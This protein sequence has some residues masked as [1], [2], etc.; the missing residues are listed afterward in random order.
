LDMDDIITDVKAQYDN[1]AK[2]SW[3]DA[4]KWYYS[5]YEELR[6]TAGKHD[7]SL[8]NIKNEIVELNRVIQRL[9]GECENT[10]AQRCKPEGAVAEA[11]EHREVVIKDAKCKLSELGKAKQDRACEYQELMNVKL[12][13]D[14]EITTYRKLLDGEESR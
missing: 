1:I 13:L 12:A 5:K 6:E 9:T 4:E 3:A 2:K 10:K 14:I 8:C 7:D 11:E